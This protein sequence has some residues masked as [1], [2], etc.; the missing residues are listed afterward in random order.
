[1]RTVLAGPDGAA[2]NSAEVNEFREYVVKHGG[3]RIA[4][5][6]G[7]LVRGRVRRAEFIL[8]TAVESKSNV[9]M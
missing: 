1:M 9:R 5:G 6:K 4:N 3:V 2:R 8:E 7:C